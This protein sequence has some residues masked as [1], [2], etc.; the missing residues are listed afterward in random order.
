VLF[1][2]GCYCLNDQSIAGRIEAMN[3]AVWQEQGENGFLTG[4]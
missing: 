4:L 1:D 3:F 2:A